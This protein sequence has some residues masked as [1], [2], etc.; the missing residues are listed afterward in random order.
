MIA[1]TA[2]TNLLSPSSS[3][4]ESSTNDAEAMA[5]GIDSLAVETPRLVALSHGN[6]AQGSFPERNI[7]EINERLQQYR[8]ILGVPANSILD[9]DEAIHEANFEDISMTM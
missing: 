5:T 8:T 9:H 7:R 3:E 2:K 1:S 4:Q 6:L